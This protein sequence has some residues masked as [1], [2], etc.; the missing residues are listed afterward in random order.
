MSIKIS[1]LAGT[2]V[3]LGLGLLVYLW[4][5]VYMEFSWTDPWVYVYMALWPFVLFFKALFW[6]IIIVVAIMVIF[7]AFK[8]YEDHKCA[9]ARRNIRTIKKY[10]DKKSR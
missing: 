3:Y 5:G 6:V 10:V 4:L 9:K 7:F 8:M 2:A 1:G